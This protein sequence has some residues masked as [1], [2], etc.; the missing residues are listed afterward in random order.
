MTCTFTNTNTN[1]KRGHIIIDKV[2]LPG[3]DAQLFDFSLTGGPDNI[4]QSFSLTN[5]D[6][7]RDSG[8]IR[9]GTV[10]YLALQTVPEGWDPTEPSCSSSLGTST[11]ETTILPSASITLGPGDTVTCVFNNIKRGTIV[12]E[13][14]VS[15][16]APIHYEQLF[17][18]TL[19]GPY[20]YNEF[21]QLAQ[22]PP[23][24]IITFEFMPSGDYSLSESTVDGW[25]LDSITCTDSIGPVSPIMVDP[26]ETVTCIVTN[27][28]QL[29]FGSQGFWR[30]WNN[31]YTDSEMDTL[32]QWLINYNP[33]VYADPDLN[34]GIVDDIFA[35][36]GASTDQQMLAKLTAVKL[37]LAA[38]GTSMQMHYDLYRNCMVDLSPIDGAEIFFQGESITVGDVVSYLEAE[39]DGNLAAGTSPSALTP[40]P[41][42]RGRC[43]AR[44]STIFTW[45]TS[46]SL[47]L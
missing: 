36:G 46:S 30:N 39:W 4:T 37:D 45:A 24:N 14:T 1:T 29:Y 31:H 23:D 18:F 20:D 42:R 7:P 15:G 26:G 22:I 28:M 12:I 32:I 41:T 9:P 33:Q 25:V 2:T 40:Y 35:F 21:S 5:G 8:W 47:T 11:T 19:T 3:G 13:K 16:P 34:R 6:P 38:T 27:K 10:G 17:D 44:C 43:S